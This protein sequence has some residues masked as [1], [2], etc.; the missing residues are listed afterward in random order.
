MLDVRELAV[1]VVCAPMAGGVS[2]PSLAAAVSR[3][4]GLGFLAAGYKSADAVA[5]E[6]DSV[7]A[8]APRPLR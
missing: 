8:L 6:I 1:P 7:R 5:A 4:G 2:T 3:A